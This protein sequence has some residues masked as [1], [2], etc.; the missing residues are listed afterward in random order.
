MIPHACSEN[1]KAIPH[2]EICGSA[3]PMKISRRT[4]R[5]TPTNGQ[6]RPTSKLT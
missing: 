5:Y 3:T 4:T 6:T 2:E 1:A